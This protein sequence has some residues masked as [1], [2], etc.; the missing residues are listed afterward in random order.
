M[1]PSRYVA[2]TLTVT[3]FVRMSDA[4]R[5][6]NDNFGWSRLWL[7]LVACLALAAWSAIQ[8]KAAPSIKRAPPQAPAKQLPTQRANPT[9]EP[10]P[11]C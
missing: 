5:T 3:R 6:S 4:P 11:L 8:N 7:L 1:R 2:E 10:E 9:G